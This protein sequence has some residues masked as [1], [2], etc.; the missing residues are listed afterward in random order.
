MQ[1][2]FGI[3]PMSAICGVLLSES[4]GSLPW[5]DRHQRLKVWS[6]S[7]VYVFDIW[8]SWVTIS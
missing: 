6:P 1:I 8:V 4:Q 5:S 3:S 7:A 2:I